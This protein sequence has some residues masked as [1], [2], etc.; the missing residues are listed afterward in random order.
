M[1]FNWGG[2]LNK[3]QEA[4]LDI[5]SDGTSG[6]VGYSSSSIITVSVGT[7]AVTSCVP[8]NWLDTDGA[9]N[10]MQGEMVVIKPK[11]EVLS[12][13]SKVQKEEVLTRFLDI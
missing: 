5:T 9:V 3:Q 1:S 13:K 11:K 4:P 10:I 8:M 2:F 6:I 12:K 7:S